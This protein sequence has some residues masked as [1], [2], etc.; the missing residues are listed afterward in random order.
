MGWWLPLRDFL[1]SFFS[2]SFFLPSFS[3]ERERDGELDLSLDSRFS[4][5]FY[6]CNVSYVS[7]FEIRGDYGKFL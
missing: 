5:S 2:L 7:L 4:F 3:F 1:F 6:P